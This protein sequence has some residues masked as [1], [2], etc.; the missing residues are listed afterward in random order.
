MSPGGGLFQGMDDTATVGFLGPDPPQKRDHRKFDKDRPRPY[1]DWN[2]FHAFMD[3]HIEE[4]RP[5][6]VDDIILHLT[7]VELAP[8]KQAIREEDE[9]K[10]G[11]IV[12]P[13]AHNDEEL[14]NLKKTTPKPQYSAILKAFNTLYG[15][16]K[17]DQVEGAMID[18]VAALTE[19]N[20]VNNIKLIIG[21]DEPYFGKMLY[22]W[23]AKGYDRAKISVVEFID[24]FLPFRFENKPKQLQKCF[25]ILDIDHDRLL[26]ILNL[27]HLN[28][29]LTP[30][31]LLSQEVIRIID[32]Y[33]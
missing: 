29:N 11:K 33:L 14:A 5:A 8:V 31:T 16:N 9:F 20:F 30:R 19:Q 10:Q 4:D 1:L 13:T 32:E 25:E 15:H 28:K 26:N 3:E 12:M 7:G 23:M 2:E 24:F 18:G 27:L 22:L 21:V 17:E 6:I